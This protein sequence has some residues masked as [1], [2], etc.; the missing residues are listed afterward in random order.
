MNRIALLCLLSLLAA[1]A[2]AVQ[3]DRRETAQA[4][5][6]AISGLKAHRGIATHCERDSDC[7]VQDIGNCCGSYP[8]CVRVDARPDPEAVASECAR[9]GLAGICG[10]PDI[11]TCTCVE[12]Q[13]A[14]AGASQQENLR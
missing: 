7:T 14:A 10:F 4:S 1:C 8:A 13:C 5:A 3:P 11:S 9:E 12:G 6:A 2:A